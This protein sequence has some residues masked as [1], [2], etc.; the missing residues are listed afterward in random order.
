MKMTTG[1]TRDSKAVLSM[2]QFSMADLLLA[3]QKTF[4]EEARRSY[5]QLAGKLAAEKSDRISELLSEL[6]NVGT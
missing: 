3:A 4:D 5:G 6:E 2:N 1:K